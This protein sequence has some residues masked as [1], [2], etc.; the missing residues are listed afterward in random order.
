MTNLTDGRSRVQI[1]AE[2]RYVYFLLNAQTGYEAQPATYSMGTG[3][4]FAGGKAA[5]GCKADHFR[6]SS[7]ELKN[8]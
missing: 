3:G 6:S 8:E 1:G 7:A 2:A 5:A 4:S